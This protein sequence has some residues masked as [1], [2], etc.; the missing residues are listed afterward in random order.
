MSLFSY[1]T[2]IIE[3]VISKRIILLILAQQLR[4]LLVILR[5]HPLYIG[6]VHHLV[7]G[8][9]G[10]LDQPV[11]AAALPRRQVLLVHQQLVDVVR[12]PVFR[13]FV[14]LVAVYVQFYLLG[15]GGGEQSGGF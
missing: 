10:L 12:E 3:E 1:I 9:H 8:L 14:E 5:L 2:N 6:I 4:L 11:P 13:E 15:G 7:T